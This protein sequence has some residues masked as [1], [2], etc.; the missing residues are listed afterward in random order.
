M[1]T[2][3][4]LREH[5]EDNLGWVKDEIAR[6]EETRNPGIRQGI[7]DRLTMMQQN[8]RKVLETKERGEERELWVAYCGFLG[9]ILSGVQVNSIEDAKRPLQF[10]EKQVHELVELA[11]QEYDKVQRIPAELGQIIRGLQAAEEALTHWKDAQS[12]EQK[13]ALLAHLKIIISTGKSILEKKS[14]PEKLLWARYCQ[15]LNDAHSDIEFGR[16]ED[17]QKQLKFAWDRASELLRA[18]K[19]DIKAASRAA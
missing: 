13:Q 15:H 3:L 12:N 19:I 4:W 2:L 6:W 1:D 17:A 9:Q 7:I 10:A 16:V 5:L 8:G 11:K 14:G 18:E